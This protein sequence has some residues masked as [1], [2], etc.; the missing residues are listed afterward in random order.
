LPDAFKAFESDGWSARAGTYD[1][2]M[3]RAT[4]FAVEPLLDAARVRPGLRVLDVGC[5]LGALAAAAAAR[6]AEVTGVDL[7]PGMLEEARRR[8]PQIEFLLADAEALPFGDGAFDVA[9]GAFLVNHL[10]HPETA[11]KELARVARRVALAM[12]GPEEEVGL[13]GLPARAA[14][15]LDAAVPPGPDSLRF[16]DADE[17]ARLIDGTV[18]EISPTLHIDSP[19]ELWEGVQG[20]TVRTAARLAAATPAQRAAARER[21]RELAEPYRTPEGYAL[22]TTIRIAAS[23]SP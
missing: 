18:T 21:L 6:G 13:L 3:A 12:W 14:R 22:P 19:D 20:G 11:A 8:H 1:A 7:A 23:L 4:A 2:L 10:P 16:T 9:L 5:G 15:D 17:L